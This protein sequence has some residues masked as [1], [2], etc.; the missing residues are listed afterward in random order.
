MF[1]NITKDLVDFDVVLI[2]EASQLQVADSSIAIE[3]LK[4]NVGRIV[5]CGDHCSSNLC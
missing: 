3:R 1:K 4:K 2:D 5:V